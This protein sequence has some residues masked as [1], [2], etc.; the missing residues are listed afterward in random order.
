MAKQPRDPDSPVTRRAFSRASPHLLTPL[1]GP[2]FSERLRHRGRALCL[3]RHHRAGL[4]GAGGTHHP[5]GKS[6][7]KAVSASGEGAESSWALPLHQRCRDGRG[8]SSR[9]SW[10]RRGG[11]G[12]QSWTQGA[13]WPGGPMLSF[14]VRRQ[15]VQEVKLE[16]VNIKKLKVSLRIFYR[17][18][19]S[20]LGSR[21]KAKA[22]WIGEKMDSRISI[23]S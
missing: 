2:S 11:L 18:V 1:S 22:T 23:S 7:W 17:G 10:G 5:P 4:R 19:P 21:R 9:V 3:I 15:E 13:D 14:V 20:I 8:E 16:S 12:G 6:A